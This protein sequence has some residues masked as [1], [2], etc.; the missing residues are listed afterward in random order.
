MSVEEQPIADWA[1]LKDAIAKRAGEP[2]RVVVKRGAE[3]LTLTPTPAATGKIGVAPPIAHTRTSL[4][5]ALV[6][7]ITEP[8]KVWLT[9]ARGM[10]RLFAKPEPVQAVGPVGLVREVGGRDEPGRLETATKFVALLNAY[11]FWLPS[12]LALL[13]FPRPPKQRSA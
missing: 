5:E 7:G 13:I 9:M 10:M 6:L 1:A 2:T 3:T 4:G 12:L 11:F 8:P